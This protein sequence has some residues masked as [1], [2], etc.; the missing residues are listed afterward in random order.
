MNYIQSL[1]LPSQQNPTVEYDQNQHI[2]RSV[3]AENGFIHT[4]LVPKLETGECTVNTIWAE[5]QKKNT[6]KPVFG[7][8]ELIK[9][10]T[11]SSAKDGK[12]TKKWSYF[13]LGDYKWMTY[14]EA[15]EKIEKIACSLQHRGFKKGD[16]II[17]FS[18]TRAEWM[19]TALAA[20]SI[21]L[22]VTTA[23]DSMPAD[24]VNHIIKETNAKAIFTEIALFPI[25]NKAYDKLDKKDQPRFVFYAGKEFEAPGE[26]D[27]FRKNQDTDVQMQ[28]YQEV[29]ENAKI[30]MKSSQTPKPE[31]LA[32]IMY[33][34]GSTGA[35]K[36][37]ELTHANII[38]ALGAAEYLVIEFI[39]KQKHTYIGFLPLAHV[40]EFILEFIMIAMGIPIGYANTRTLT[41]DF[42]CGPNG[43]GKG[44]GDLKALKPTIMAGVPAIWEKIKKGVETDLSKKH[45]MISKAFHA[46]IEVKWRLLTFFGQTNVITDTFD[47]YVFAPVRAATGG[48]LCYAVSGGAPLSLETQ[49]F[50]TSTLCFLLQG[51]G[52]TE[53]C[54]LGAITLPGNGMITSAIGAPSPSVEFKLVD[55]PETDY[56]AK[57]NVGELWIR[58]PS[59][60]RG[61]HKRPDLTEEALTPD[62][63]FKTGDIARLNPDGTFSIFDRA[64]NLV[65]LSHG[66]YIALESLES[67][68]RN[69]TKI[70]NICLVAESDKSYIVAIV[71][72][73]DKKTDKDTILS[74]MQKTAESTG[75]SKVETVQDVV[76]TRDKEW[77]NEYTTT[78]GKIKRRDIVKAYQDDKPVDAVEQAHK[79]LRHNPLIDTHNDLPMWLAFDERGKIN[80]LN[81]TQVDWGHTDITRLREGHVGGQFWSIYFDCFESDT[82]QILKAMESIDATRRMIDLYPDTFRFVTNTKEFKRAIKHGRIASMLGMEGGQMI[83]NSLAA[84][85]QFYHLGIRYMTLTHNCHTEWAESCCDHLPPPFEAGLGLTEFGKAVVLEMNRLGMMVDI[86]HVSHSTM[87][88]VLNVTRAPV[89]F[90]HSSS[91]A[92]CP[93]ERNVPDTVLRRLNETD[94]VVMVNFYNAFVQCDHEIEATLEDVVNHIEYIA[95]I[96]G[97]DRVGLGADYNGIE[98]TPKGLEDVSKYPDLFAELIRR[99]WTEEQLIGLA[100]KNLLR[101]WMKVEK[102]SHKLTCRGELP[103]ED[104]L[105]DYPLIK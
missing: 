84:L 55:V 39:Y 60:M 4:P 67:K 73:Q 94:G 99:G 85:R 62:G 56:K 46:A 59:I 103:S 8:R 42:I 50:V 12:G 44:V 38:A 53:C 97:Y 77:M 92:L 83:D 29:I 74:E 57:D 13:E 51:Y 24:A 19:L 33:T 2:F 70:K 79:L 82:N 78:S 61:Y 102:V 75:C 26:V 18:K 21:G 27:K 16:I 28:T 9:I 3:H 88:A 5:I 68:Y 15:N 41:D 25:L 10:H 30:E 89:L 20:L 105:E 6:D 63:W 66:E 32:L 35:P 1:F 58:G 91:H 40:L 47:A 69:C 11:R 65:K 80:H 64:K 98:Q 14:K 7:T 104:R 90:S 76:V 54:G 52:L 37:V 81:L 17:L 36:G 95:S 43:E 101:V 72:P 86:S 31:D 49:K 100:G 45:W 87:H 48:H 93:I 34:S 22:V 96:V 71:E 23:Y